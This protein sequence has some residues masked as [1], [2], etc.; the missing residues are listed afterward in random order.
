MTKS[1]HILPVM[2]HRVIKLFILLIIKFFSCL[3]RLKN[4][5][6]NYNIHQSKRISEIAKYQ[7]FLFLIRTKIRFVI[8]DNLKLQYPFLLILLCIL[9]FPL[10]RI[11]KINYKIRYTNTISYGPYIVHMQLSLS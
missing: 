1:Y 2:K 5:I 6:I 9:H 3:H 11:S 8:R 4:L 7:S 10:T